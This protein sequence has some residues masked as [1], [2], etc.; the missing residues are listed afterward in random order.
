MQTSAT[1]AASLRHVHRH[2]FHD[3]HLAGQQPFTQRL[4]VHLG[5]ARLGKH[6]TRLLFFLDVVL[7]HLREHLDLGVVVLVVGAGGLDFGN[8]LLCAVVFDLG[9]V[10]DL[11][12][13][14][15]GKESRIENLFLDHR[16]NLE[17]IADLGGEH[18]LAL[19]V[20][21]LLELRE[22]RFRLAM[23]FL[24]QC[25]RVLLSRGAAGARRGPPR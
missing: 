20:P 2:L 5:L 21:C 4:Q 22:Q 19:V 11:E 17:R 25:D 14:G 6:A 15:G 24:E 23:V 1:A 12:V 9:L 7:D 16:V 3:L 8:E 13:L 10:M 18:L